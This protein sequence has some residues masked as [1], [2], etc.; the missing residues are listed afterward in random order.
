MLNVEQDYKL[1]KINNFEKSIEQDIRTN[2]KEKKEFA[3]ALLHRLQKSMRLRSSSLLKKLNKGKL[4]HG[5]ATTFYAR[6]ETW[7]AACLVLEEEME[8]LRDG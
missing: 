5:T 8:A 3:Y 4:K 6:A 2:N 7:E 1:Q